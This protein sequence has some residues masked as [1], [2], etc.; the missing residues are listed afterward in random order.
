MTVPSFNYAGKSAICPRKTP[1][2][3]F[4]SLISCNIRSL[5]AMSEHSKCCISNALWRASSSRS[6]RWS[7]AK[8]GGTWGSRFG[9]SAILFYERSPIGA[10][11]RPV[12]PI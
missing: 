1:M 9:K 11:L 2:R 12:S 5:S 8:S 4:K 3:A 6:R 7:A 10:Y